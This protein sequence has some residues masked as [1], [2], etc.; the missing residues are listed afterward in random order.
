MTKMARIHTRAPRVQ[1]AY[2]SM[3]L[4]L[5]QRLT[6]LAALACDGL[7]ATKSIEASTSTPVLLSYLEQVLEPALKR[8]GPDAILVMDNCDRVVQLRWVSVSTG[9]GTG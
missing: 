2:G 6:V 3:P 5:R 8:T 9:P 4:G 1:R 7:V